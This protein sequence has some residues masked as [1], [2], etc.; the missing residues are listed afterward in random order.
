[1][2]NRNASQGG[3]KRVLIAVLIMANLLM[4]VI[5]IHTIPPNLGSAVGKESSVPRAEQ[6]AP[7]TPSP[8]E[9]ILPP[10]TESGSIPA[11][12]ETGAGLSTEERP[13]L[14]DFL[15][16]SED[17]HHN[18]IPDEATFI[19]DFNTI[20][21]GWKGFIL[22]D[23]ENT[24]DMSGMEF[25]NAQITGTANELILNLDWYMVYWAN[26]E[27]SVDETETEDDF[28][29]GKWENGGVTASDEAVILITKFYELYGN[30]Y[31][32]GTIK[33]LNGIPAF[34]ALVRP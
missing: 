30:Q 32:V 17:V 14:G 31:A 25:L 7:A 3:E 28:Y 2:T 5:G 24:H 13:D 8:E 1:M 34:I 10:T 18:G 12:E 15:W 21:G 20:T 6:T 11:S 19:K 9:E 16:Y 26:E 4:L 23:P 29:T 27:K 22:Y 33:T